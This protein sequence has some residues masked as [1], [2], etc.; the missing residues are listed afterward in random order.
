MSTVEG[1]AFRFAHGGGRCAPRRLFRRVGVHD[2]FL[3]PARVEGG[4]DNNF[5]EAVRSAL[6]LIQGMEARCRKFNL[7]LR[8]AEEESDRHGSFSVDGNS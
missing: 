4:R 6:R 1:P 8:R 7:M 5:S 3:G 2:E